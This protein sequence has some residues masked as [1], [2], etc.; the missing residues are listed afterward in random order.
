[1][2][3]TASEAHKNLFPLIEQVNDDRDAVLMYAPILRRY[4]R[5]RIC[6]MRRPTR[7]DSWRACSRPPPASGGTRA[8]AMRLVFTPHGWQDYTAW[9]VANR[10]VLKRIN[11]LIDDALRDPSPC[12]STRT[13]T[14]SRS[15]T[16]Y[17]HQRQ[18]R[19]ALANRRTG[20][21]RG[22]RRRSTTPRTA[23][24]GCRRGRR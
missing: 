12:T 16:A 3:I 4:R 13:P 23:V 11:R 9:L 19:T 17:R 18:M 21:R 5:R 8:P 20:V 24:S 1:M 6:F 14:T 7:A 15:V 2:A 22:G 10:T